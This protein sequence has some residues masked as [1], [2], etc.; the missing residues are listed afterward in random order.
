ME[1]L[2]AGDTQAHAPESGRAA[3]AWLLWGVL[4]LIVLAQTQAAL[5]KNLK[6]GPFVSGADLFAALL[7]GVWALHALATGAWRRVTWPPLAAGVLVVVAIVAA[8]RADSPEAVKSAVVDV[9]QYVLYFVCVYL[10]FVNALSDEARVRRVVGLLG[11]LTTVMVVVALAQY[12]L[13]AD[14]ADPDHTFVRVSSTFGLGEL[15][16][17]T[18]LGE[19]LHLAGKSSRSIYCN[20]LLLVL[21]VLFVVGLRADGW[22][23]PALLAT[24]A[25][26][27]LTMLSGWHFWALVAVLLALSLRHSMKVALV[28]A[29]AVVLVMAAGRYVLPRNYQANLVEL[30]DVHEEGVLDEQAV[31]S[32]DFAGGEVPTTTEVKKR[33]IEWQPAL[34]MVRDNPVLGVGTGGYQLHI[35]Q[36]YGM[37]PNFKKIEP[38][39]NCGWLVV[40]GSMGLCGLIALAA[41]FASQYRAAMRLAAGAASDALRDVSLGLAGSML[42]LFLA[43]LFSNVFVRGLSITVILLLALVTSIGSLGPN[44]P[45]KPP[46]EAD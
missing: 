35:G 26:G 30:M 25:L 15:L 37:L 31:V 14:P 32:E 18:P 20:Y 44:R 34:N 21:P 1:T 36:N 2:A 23:R 42:G 45:T 11:A 8:G 24:V 16:A 4:L 6:D 43:M 17:K 10:L 41:L 7:F 19:K 3:P 29:L 9:A 13:W 22:R 33:W 40:A 12:V 39:T 38:D 27:M 28:L 5:A 46:S